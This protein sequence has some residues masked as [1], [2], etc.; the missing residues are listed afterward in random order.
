MDLM[1]LKAKCENDCF[2]SAIET[3]K[4]IFCFLPFM[5][6]GFSKAGQLLVSFVNNLKPVEMCN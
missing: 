5:F 3:L 4:W 6:H 1:N 2:K